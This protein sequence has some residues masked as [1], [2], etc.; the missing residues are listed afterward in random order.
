[1]MDMIDM[2]GIT[3]TSLLFEATLKV[4]LVLVIA[5]A[6]V[7]CL[8]RRSVAARHWVLSVAILCALL[9]SVL[10]AVAPTWHLPITTTWPMT[11]AG[12]VGG[13][14]A[15]PSLPPVAGP[16]ALRSGRT[17]ASGSCSRTSWR[18][19][20]VETGACRCAPRSCGRPSGSTR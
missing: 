3:T 12:P 9:L 15:E 13:P 4:S 14:D 17:N 7:W 16:P 20:D 10:S 8:R 1:M 18:T 2:T 19:S 6:V 11:A 5:L